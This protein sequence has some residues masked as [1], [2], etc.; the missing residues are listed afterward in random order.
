M[1]SR[2]AH[3]LKLK[4][5][6]Y[7]KPRLC[8]VGNLLGQNPGY[9]TTQGQIIA[10][11]FSES[12]FGVVTASSRVNSLARLFDVVWTLFRHRQTI[13]LVIAEIYSGRGFVIA[14]V[15]SMIGKILRIPTVGVLHGGDLPR[16]CADN[17]RRSAR[18][19]RRFDRLVAPSTF[20]AKAISIGLTAPTVI[21]NVIDITTYPHAVRRQ[22]E[23][24]LLWMRA[25]HQ[26][27]NPQMAI[28]VLKSL[29][30]NYPM[31]S[32]VMAGVDKGLE[33]EIQKLANDLGLGD[34]V[35]FPGFLDHDAKIREFS[36]AD[37]FL[38]TNHIDNMPVGVVEA[39]AMGLPVVATRV[40]GIPDLIEDGQNGLLVPDDDVAA[41]TKAVETLLRD[42]QLAERLSLS[43]RKLAE[44][45]SWE[46][47]RILWEELFKD[48][49]TT[50]EHNVV[51]F[52][53]SEVSN[54]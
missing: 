31:A 6:T 24:R 23:P 25:F 39:C 13:D 51:G 14:D 29:K 46:E 7:K 5:M 16:F 40:G 48:V 44:R 2:Y 10:G 32:L 3:D 47:V 34:S 37:I 17:P 11:R 1:S 49:L 27:Y 22:P 21:P 45:S 12:G 52:P 15:A 42:T 28:G 43:G 33:P 8:V 9:V 54:S 53:A 26:I 50:K 30:E 36:Q 4:P 20:L 18:V 19:L 41:M 35:R 38:N